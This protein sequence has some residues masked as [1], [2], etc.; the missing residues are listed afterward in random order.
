[1]VLHATLIQWRQYVDKIHIGVAQTFA[2][3]NQHETIISCFVVVSIAVLYQK[4]KYCSVNEIEKSDC[5][6][7]ILDLP[8]KEIY[9][10]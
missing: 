10:L 9:N 5:G 6:K 3:V 7:F 8:E 1:M 4:I 2:I